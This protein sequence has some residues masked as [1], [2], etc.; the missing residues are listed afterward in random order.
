[1]GSTRFGGASRF[2]IDQKKYKMT[3][4]PEYDPVIKPEA[5]TSPQFS[6]YARRA[7]KGFDPLILMNST[8]EV[9]GPGSYHPENSS[10]TSLKQNMPTWSVPKGPRDPTNPGKWQFNETYDQYSSLGMQTRSQKPTKPYFSV[11]KDKRGNNKSGVFKAH[12]EFKPMQVRIQH[13]RFWFDF[14]FHFN[15]YN[16]ELIHAKIKMWVKF[17]SLGGVLLSLGLD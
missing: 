17:Q 7:V 14:Y 4:G 8:S 1:M 12:M 9:V 6:L 5:K 16:F 3:P 2:P 10:N 11:G 13:P 15:N